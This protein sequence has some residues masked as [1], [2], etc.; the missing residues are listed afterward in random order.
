LGYLIGVFNLGYLIMTELKALI[1]DVDGTLADTEKYGHRV[2]FNQAFAQADLPWEW[3]VSLYQEILA[4]AGGKE[5]IRYY[6]EKYQPD[7][8]NQFTNQD[9]LIKLIANLHAQKNQLYKNLL[10]TGSIPLRPGVVRLLQAARQANIQ[11]AIASTSAVENVI[12]LLEFA[13]GKDSLDWFQVIAAG[14]IVAKKKPAPDIY[15]Y[16]LE[17]MQLPAEQCLVFEDTDQGLTAATRA[18]LSTVITMS[19]YTQDEDFTGAKLV[20][21]H[22][23]DID[24]PFTIKYSDLPNI[25]ETYFT[26]DLARVILAGK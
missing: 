14:D 12:A 2:A 10:T 26:L 20:L 18:G 4:I 17:K 5:R 13:L 22:L 15:L 23:G 24:Q 8:F 9:E 7:F 16:V 21:N 19:D 1:F 25:T 3:S 6:I 11:L